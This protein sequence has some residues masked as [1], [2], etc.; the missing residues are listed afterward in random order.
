MNITLDR[1]QLTKAEKKALE[2][3]NNQGTTYG[4]L[5]KTSYGNLN[6]GKREEI[7]K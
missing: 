6:G 7:K 2:K 5:A 3:Q 1:G 4:A